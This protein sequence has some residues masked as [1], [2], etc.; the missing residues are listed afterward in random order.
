MNIEF[1]IEKTDGFLNNTNSDFCFPA[2]AELL[3]NALDEVFSS[4]YGPNYPCHEF[5]GIFFLSVDDFFSPT[6]KPGL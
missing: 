6:S 2:F 5:F 3:D 4:L 1:A